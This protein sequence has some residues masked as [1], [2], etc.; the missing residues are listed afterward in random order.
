[1]PSS[2]RS[3]RPLLATHGVGPQTAAQLL[4]TIGDNPGRLTSEAA[5]AALTGTSPVLASSGRTD[6]HRL[7]RGGDRHAN[8][9]LHHIVVVRMKS[10]QP[11]PDY[12]AKRDTEKLPKKHTMRCLKRYLV[13][14]IYRAIRTDLALPTP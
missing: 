8:S 9:A 14:E 6:R 13:R 7:N 3:P 2:P 4:F 10:H 11:T 5:L 1:V 12:I